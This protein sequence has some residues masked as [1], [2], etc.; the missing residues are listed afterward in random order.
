[1]RSASTSLTVAVITLVFIG[2]FPCM[3]WVQW[4]GSLAA[5][6]ALVTGIVGLVTDEESKSAHILAIVVGVLGGGVAALRLV[7]GAGLF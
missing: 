1:M 7:L 6:A 4:I 5:A 2:I 3:G